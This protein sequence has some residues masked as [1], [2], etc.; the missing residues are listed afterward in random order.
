MSVS[1]ER[2]P[3]NFQS[4][5]IGGAGRGGMPPTYQECL[6]NRCV[7]LTSGT[8]DVPGRGIIRAVNSNLL[9]ISMVYIL[10]ANS[11]CRSFT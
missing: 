9:F 1:R 2:M 7:V 8:G 6:S 10:F 11:P 5:R 3:G 4:L